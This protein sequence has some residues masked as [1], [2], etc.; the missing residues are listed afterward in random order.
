MPRKPEIN[1]HIYGKLMYDKGG[2]NIQWRRDI[3]WCLENW[4]AECLKNEIR[5]FSNT[6]YNNKLK[7]D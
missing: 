5:T 1:P 3:K 2:K 7:I 4:I 6:I